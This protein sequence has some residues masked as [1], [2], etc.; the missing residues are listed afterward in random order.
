LKVEEYFKEKKIHNLFN[1]EIKEIY[2]NKKNLQ[3]YLDHIDS[4]NVQEGDK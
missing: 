4:H 2:F 3:E 1:I